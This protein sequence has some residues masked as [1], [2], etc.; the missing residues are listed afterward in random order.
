MSV[1]AGKKTATTRA[2][3]LVALVVL[4]GLFALFSRVHPQP[5]G[6]GV[7]VAATGLLLLCGM[8]TSELL[9]PL[10]LPHLTGYIA[11]GVTLG[12]HALHFIDHD[13]VKQLEIVNTLALA[14]IALAG[15][16]ELRTAD[17]RVVLRSLWVST[18]VQ[19]PVV[20]LTQ[21]ALFFG[22]SGMLPFSRNLTTYGLL[23]TAALWGVLAVSRSPS[24]TLAILS[25]T[26]AKGPLARFSLAFVMSSDVVVLVLMAITIALVRPLVEPSGGGASTEELQAVG[27]ELLGS[28]SVGTTLGLMLI[29]YMRLVGS[30]VLV[31]L[32]ALGF[33]LSELLRYLEVEPLLT[34]LT[35][36]FVVQNL[37]SQG[38]K[39]LHVIEETGS[40][41]FVVFFATAG[42]HLDVPL[43]ARMWPVALSLAAG[44]M[45]V[46]FVAQRVSG[47]L[48]DDPPLLRRWGFAS[49]VSQAGL[50]LGLSAVI[51]RTFPSI[52]EG[53]RSLVVATVAINEVIGPIFFKLA[54]ERAGEVES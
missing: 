27:H 43:L 1:A 2:A 44:R 48:A 53:I 28:V 51:V 4:V 50:T 7:V 24:A 6:S 52:G 15:G 25:Q 31:L 20:F 26:R 5:E 45:V 35:A 49:M 32:V 42:A 11:A 41:V 47:R 33:A 46:T 9:E 34:F 17:V 37:S 30:H 21:A 16:L 38:D 22:L 39:L 10:R 12:P 14:L 40:V 8:L 18:S 23:G 13:T 29:A 54:L 3:Q 19:T 36:G